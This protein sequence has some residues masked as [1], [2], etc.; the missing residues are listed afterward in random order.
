MDSVRHSGMDW[1]ID[2]PMDKQT[3]RQ[4]NRPPID[5]QPVRQMDRSDGWL[6]RQTG[7]QTDKQ[8]SKQN[9]QA[10]K[11]DGQSESLNDDPRDHLW[12]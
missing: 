12:G 8:T 7:R 9:R 2:D 6:G 3:N 10:N 5:K 1:Q 11:T 4:L